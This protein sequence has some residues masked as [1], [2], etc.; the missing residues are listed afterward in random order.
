[1]L[2]YPYNSKVKFKFLPTNVQ[3]VNPLKFENVDFPDGIGFK[4]KNCGKCCKD[5]PADVNKE[6]QKR[7]EALGFT[8]FLEPP[9]GT[10]QRIIKRKKNGSCLFFTD[11]NKCLIYSVR[12]MICQL[13][14]FDIS[15]WDYEKDIIIVDFHPETKCPGISDKGSLPVEVLG[16][17]AQSF[18][19][20]MLETVS[21]KRHLPKSNKE[22]L[23]D[24][25][26]IIMKPWG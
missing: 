17:A 26:L 11:D 21:K 14:P 12:P 5:Q 19:Q 2:I 3:Q 6:E 24:T 15:D 13:T 1:M 22:V 16:R 10:D 25:R 18:V 7:I 20:E 9:D 4:C 23:F 8:D